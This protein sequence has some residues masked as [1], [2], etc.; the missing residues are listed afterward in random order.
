MNIDEETRK[1]VS[2]LVGPD[3]KMVIPDD[4][5][6]DLKEVITYLN[7]NNINILDT[8]NLDDGIVDEENDADIN[9]DDDDYDD[10][11]DDMTDDIEEETITTNH[12][13]D[14]ISDSNIDELNDLF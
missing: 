2:S 7:R 9:S 8:T 10:M 13:S 5:P 14:E 6:D 12:I 4:F 3:G 11:D 1:K